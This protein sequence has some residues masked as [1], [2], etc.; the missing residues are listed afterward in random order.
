MLLCVS[1]FATLFFSSCRKNAEE[2]AALLE[3]SEAAEILESNV[4]ERSAGATMPTIDMSQII[5]SYLQ[6]CGIPGD[7][8]LQRSRTTGAVT[9]NYTFNLGWVLHCSSLNVPQSADITI[10]G[11]GSF[12]T[13]RWAGADAASGTLTLTGLNPQATAY[14][15]NGAYTLE[16]DL[17]GSLRKSNPTLHCTTTLNLTDL[18]IRKS[19]NQISGGTG[20][21]V[22]T[23]T[24]G[25]G[26]S[27]TLNGTLVFNGD[28]TVTVTVNGHVHT[29]PIQ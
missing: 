11:N 14:L 3:D 6:N 13:Q 25:K 16:G 4:A 21:A 1:L 27:E 28:G 18:S 24:N 10:G 20:T 9:Y 2:I 29:F 22:I 5:E 19:D 23:A 12:N 8:T 15:F 26:Q 17:T 7:T